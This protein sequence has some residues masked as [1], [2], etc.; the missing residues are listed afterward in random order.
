MLIV[1]HKIAVVVLEDFVKV[2]TNKQPSIRHRLDEA[3]QQQIDI[4][5][6]KMQSIIETIIL[7]GRQNIALRGHRDS[8]FEVEKDPS[9][10]HGN[11]WALLEV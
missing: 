3:A 4:N 2:M 9:A 6:E 5:R 11:F 10:P 1:Y 7:R 8:F